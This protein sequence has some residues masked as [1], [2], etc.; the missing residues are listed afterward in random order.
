MLEYVFSGLWD[1]GL[2]F[3]SHPFLGSDGCV[4]ESFL[5]SVWGCSCQ[6]WTRFGALVRSDRGVSRALRIERGT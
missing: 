1:Y 5:I 3:F 2:G 4:F 6:E